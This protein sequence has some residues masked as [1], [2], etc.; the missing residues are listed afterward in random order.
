MKET[1]PLR[2]QWIR[3]D[4]PVVKEILREFS[5]LQTYIHV[6]LVFKKLICIFILTEL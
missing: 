4:Y 3:E 6:R 2:Q 5:L 1:L